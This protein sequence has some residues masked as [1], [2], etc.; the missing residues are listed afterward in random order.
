MDNCLKKEEEESVR[1][2]S[3]RT[4]RDEEN[5]SGHTGAQQRT[6]GHFSHACMARLSFVVVISLGL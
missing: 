2:Q 3:E 1:V 5:E 6:S 4:R